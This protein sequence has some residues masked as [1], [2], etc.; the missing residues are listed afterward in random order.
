[1]KKILLLLLFTYTLSNAQEDAWVYFNDKPDASF[2]LDNPLE[3]LSQKALDRRANQGIELDELDV[4]VSNVYIDAVAATNGI[5]VMAKSKWLNALHIRGSEEAI[6]TLTALNF[7]SRVDFADN[8]LD[9]F[10]RA[11][12]PRPATSAARIKNIQ[13]TYN[14]GSS[15]G[16][17]QML[18]GHLLHQQDFTGA[19]KTIAVLDNGFV[20]VPTAGAFARL[21]E[22]NLIATGYNYVQHSNDV[23]TGGSHGTMV[24]STMGGYASGQLVGSAPDAFYY[25]FVTEDTAAEN[26][27]EESYWVEAAEMADSLGVDIINTSLGYLNYDNP[28]YSHTYNNANGETAFIT[29]GANVAFTR[30]MFLVTSAGNSAATDQPNISVPADA[31]N[32]LTVGAVGP[33]E[34]YAYFSSIGPSADGRIKPDVMAQGLL[35]TVCSADGTIAA[36]SGTSFSGP[37]T[38]GMVACLWQAL[39]NK[40]NAELLQIIKESADRYTNP[41]N[42]YGYGIPDFNLALQREL[43][44]AHVAD[45][46]MFLVYPNP[47]KNHLSIKFPTSA[48]TARFIIYN[49]LGQKVREQ[50]VVNEKA[51]SLENLTSGI[52]NYYIQSGSET[53]TGRLVKE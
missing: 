48:N 36:A 30:G 40:T 7:V 26:P 38:A 22:N 31:F 1:M 2:Y 12:A 23:Y 52:Y 43:L 16:Q 24:L 45:G 53:Q 50:E 32:T 5:T 14:Y 47:V 17:V 20:G 39:P 46:N 9:D 25:L 27:V 49:S 37:I 21:Y 28:N 11:A 3:M 10:G 44:T 34:Q 41:D 51:V 6:R 18:N 15:A 19:G 4:P 33:D 35:T 42:F 13:A 8:S 29:R